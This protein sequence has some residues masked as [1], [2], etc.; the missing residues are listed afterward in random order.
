MMTRTD[1]THVEEF[2]TDEFHPIMLVQDSRIQH[3]VAVINRE[4]FSADFERHKFTFSVTHEL[5]HRKAI[6][7]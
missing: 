3:P 2:P 4:K 7:F 1:G 6:Q 5:C